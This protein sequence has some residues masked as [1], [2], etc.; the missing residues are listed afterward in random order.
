[1]AA[2]ANYGLLPGDPLETDD[3]ADPA[4]EQGV[5]GEFF[6]SGRSQATGALPGQSVPLIS[7]AR[8]DG[9][10]V[11]RQ[12]AEGMAR[13]HEG[14]VELRLSPEELGRVRMI[15]HQ[16]EHGLTVHI[17]ADRPETLDLLR[18]NI[19]ELARHLGDAGYEGAGFSFGDGQEG[20]GDQPGLADVPLP[21]DPD[22]PPEAAPAWSDPNGLD[23]RI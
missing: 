8:T 18:R 7:A 15:L 9:A 5:D 19:D 23:I 10:A 14:T 11:A 3:T 6:V 1:M 12:M 22:L 2:D 13:L 4:L 20:G 21:A 17:Q 16:G